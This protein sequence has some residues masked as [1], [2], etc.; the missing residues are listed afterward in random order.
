[1]GVEIR[2]RRIID[3]RGAS[4]RLKVMELQTLALRCM[5]GSPAQREVIAS[6]EELMAAHGLT[7]AEVNRF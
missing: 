7:L 4:V 5:A 1:M 6:Y 3:N 2:V